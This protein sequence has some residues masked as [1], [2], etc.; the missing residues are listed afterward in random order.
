MDTCV[1]RFALEYEA[2]ECGEGSGGVESYKKRFYKILAGLF[3]NN[4]VVVVLNSETGREYYRHIQAVKN[5]VSRKTRVNPSF[6]L[7]KI[8]K[9]VRRKVEDAEY[10]YTFEGEPVCRKDMHLLNSA[11]T[12]ALTFGEPVAYVITAARDVY[13]GKSA[14]NGKGIKIY[15]LNLFDENDLEIIEKLI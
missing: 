14:R 4:D 11:K 1:L 6:S 5:R 7:L 15:L 12:G 8:F 3:K 9:K 10:E 2:G 13:C